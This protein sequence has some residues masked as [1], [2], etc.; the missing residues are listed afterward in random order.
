MDDEKVAYKAYEK[1]AKAGLVT[2]CVRKGLFLRDVGKAAKDWPQLNFIICRSAYGF[3]AGGKVEDAWAQF[4]KTGRIEWVTDLSEIRRSTASPTLRRPRPDLRPEHGGRHAR[5]R[6]DDGAARQGTR[7]PTTS[8][9]A[10]TPSDRLAQWQIE[11]LRRL[12]IPEDM[13]KKHGFT[14][15]GAAGGPVK[16]AIFGE[17]NARLYKYERRAALATDRNHRDERTNTRR[18]G[19]PAA[20]FATG[21]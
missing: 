14:P 21:T 17:T 9:G 1:F 13:Q 12:E 16:T 20:I 7:A 2:L 5:V 18:A 15:L 3:A 4:E 19:R 6:G 10:P 8:S 11:A